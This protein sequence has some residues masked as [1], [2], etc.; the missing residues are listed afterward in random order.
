MPLMVGSQQIDNC[1][2]T[3]VELIAVICGIRHKIGILPIALNNNA[4]L[5]IAKICHPKPR[6]TFRFVEAPI[7]AKHLNDFLRF[8][9]LSNRF[10]TRPDIETNPETF[11]R[12]SL[13]RQDVGNA[14]VRKV[15][16]RSFASS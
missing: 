12:F 3:S 2:K 7:L 5:I 14:F 4:V 10:F 6:C 11:Q 16:T 15:P 13:L 1:S 9:T 8:P